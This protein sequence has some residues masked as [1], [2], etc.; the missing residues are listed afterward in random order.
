MNEWNK[1]IFF[2]L[3]SDLFSHMKCKQ[4]V[5]VNRIFG[6]P[7]TREYFCQWKFYGAYFAF[8]DEMFH[9]FGDFRY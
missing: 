5:Y 4:Q 9:P 7:S 3:D 1:I 2:Y 8:Y 6:L